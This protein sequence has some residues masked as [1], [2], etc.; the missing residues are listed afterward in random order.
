MIDEYKGMRTVTWLH[1]SDLHLCNPKTGWE[2]GKILKKLQEDFKQL[3]HEEGLTPDMIFF[4]GDVVFGH[5]GNEKGKQIVEQYEDAAKFFD[6]IRASFTPEIPKE[7]VFIVPGNHDV[8][9]GKTNRYLHRG[10]DSQMTGDY[11]NIEKKLNNLIGD[12]DKDDWKGFIRSLKEYRQFLELNGYDHP[13]KKDRDRLIYAVETE[14]NHVKVGIAG[15][16]S[17]WS[18]WQDNEKGKL[19]LAGHWQIQTLSGRMSSPQLKIALMH[20]PFNW[21]NPAEDSIVQREMSNNF[22]FFLHG[23][24]HLGWVEEIVGGYKRISAGACYGDSEEEMGYNMT[25]LTFGK[26]GNF[27]GKVWLRRYDR[28]GEGWVIRPVHGKAEDGVW[29]IKKGLEP[30]APV[31]EEEGDEAHET[32]GEPAVEF[33]GD[34]PESRG[35]FGREK[36][37]AKIAKIVNDVP[38]TFI[39]GMTG[40]GK[41]SL[42]DEVRRHPLLKDRQYYRY[43]ISQG[44]GLEQLFALIAPALGNRD[45]FPKENFY[46]F[47]KYDFSAL[48][49]Y[50]NSKY[51]SPCI[52]HLEHAQRIIDNGKFRDKGV[53]EFFKAI[54]NYPQFKIVI[55]GREETENILP[56][57]IYKSWDVH[58]IDGESMAT[59]FRRPFKDRPQ[60]SWSL[61]DPDK[62]FIYKWLGGN[63]SKGRA[64][65]FAMALLASLADGR[66]KTPARILKDFEERNVMIKDLDSQLF[67]DLYE[68]VLSPAQQHLLR[69]FSLYREGI[70]DLHMS[71]L[72]EA[73]GDENAFQRLKQRCLLTA[74]DRGDWYN[75]HSLIAE[76]TQKRIVVKSPHYW[77]DHDIIAGAWRTQLKISSHISPPNIQAAGHVLYHLTEA[78]NYEGYYEISDKL[79]RKDVIPHL[80]QV[81]RNLFQAKKYKEDRCVLDLLVKLE[82]SE[83]KY[84]RFLAQRIEMLKGKGDDDAFKH[85]KEAYNLLPTFP[86]HLADLGRCLLVR[87]EPKIFNEIVEKLT[88]Q[89]YNGVMDNHNLAIYATCLE[90]VGD[91]EEAS[92]LRREQIDAGSNFPSFYAD[93]ANDLLSQN[94]YKDALEII[95]KAEA[96]KC[97]NNHTLAIKAKILEESG[98][99]DE[100]SRLRREQIDAG[101]NNPAFYNDEAIYLMK[102]HRYDDA[103]AIIEKAEKRGCANEYTKGIKAKLPP[104]HD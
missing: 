96:R 91:V 48:K 31:D 92:R 47:G 49:K 22:D 64:H 35:V 17:A 62:E 81:S 83:P 8:N 42:I 77:R 25:R 3:H 23:H 16:N 70:P 100:A 19:W 45:D 37:I 11:H 44:M 6:S 84:H 9:R 86:Q 59:F 79:L 72:N 21:F 14:I 80:A 15:F 97:T 66:R 53:A 67:T 12:T 52:I 50:A 85:Y 74:N 55:E 29:F 34:T 43:P 103:R 46:L 89:E 60:V 26:D 95:G 99:E 102:K 32:T 93:E 2:S 38:I 40:I 7:R 54:A 61:N 27:T 18:S 90:K 82:P 71:R 36:E 68:Q 30:P 101:S 39:Y 63:K 10:F 20:H 88:P 28:S 56:P 87:H 94:R 78:E 4:T 33:P 104:P 75:L 73:V 65:P 51:S 57:N 24:E 76:M 13:L 98:E 41:T 58:G 69:L 5:L 1:L